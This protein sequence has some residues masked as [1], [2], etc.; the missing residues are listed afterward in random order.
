[1]SKILNINEFLDRAEREYL[2]ENKV[3][4]VF[5]IRRKAHDDDFY[6]RLESELQKQN[7]LKIHDLRLVKEKYA[8]ISR[9]SA[10]SIDLD[11]L[12]TQR[13]H[14]KLLKS[15]MGFWGERY[16]KINLLLFAKT[17]FRD[18]ME[19]LALTYSCAEVLNYLISHPEIC[20]GLLPREISHGQS[21][22]LIGKEPLLLKMFSCWRDQSSRWSDFYNYFGLLDKPAE[23]RIFAP[24][25]LLQN[26]NLKNYHGLL[27]RDFFKDYN[28]SNLNGTLIIENYESFYVAARHSKKTLILWGAGWKAASLRSISKSLPG[29]VFY[30]GDIDKEGYEIF[31]YLCNFMPDLEPLY[32][33]FKT[34]HDNPDLQQKRDK[35]L[36]PYKQIPKL[37]DEYIWICS[38]GLQIE[39]EQ[40]QPQ[41]PYCDSLS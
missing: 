39:Q 1:M 35:Y 11:T 25:C 31:A 24:E 28:F 14:L 32:M 30:W 29:P 8:K 13:S 10:V 7:I 9:P 23:F 18:S 21:T 12:L 16:P 17:Y 22:K 38:R 4:F 26:Q 15:E 41:W 20:I 36:G 5:T 33:S 6:S 2:F 27:S 40:L 37:Q 19:N 3:H 34:I